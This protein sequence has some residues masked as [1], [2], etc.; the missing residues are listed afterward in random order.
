MSV[1]ACVFVCIRLRKKGRE[2]EKERNG[3]G[4]TPGGG[5]ENGRNGDRGMRAE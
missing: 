5:N 1:Y 4:E 2:R 3:I